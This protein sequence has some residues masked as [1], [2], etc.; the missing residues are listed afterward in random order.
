MV[1]GIHN[2]FK[3]ATHCSVAMRKLQ[4]NSDQVLKYDYENKESQKKDNTESTK[5]TSLTYG[6]DKYDI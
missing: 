5:D 4:E 1:I 3:I 2:Y 6:Q